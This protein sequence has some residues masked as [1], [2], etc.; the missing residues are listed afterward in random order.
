[1]FILR[2]IEAISATLETWVDD[3]LDDKVFDNEDKLGQAQKGFVQGEAGTA[4]GW[5][6]YVEDGYTLAGFAI[7]VAEGVYVGG[8][9]Q[10]SSFHGLQSELEWLLRGVAAHEDAVQEFPPIQD[11]ADPAGFLKLM[12]SLRQLGNGAQLTATIADANGPRLRRLLRRRKDSLTKDVLWLLRDRRAFAEVQNEAPLFFGTVNF[13]G[14]LPLLG[15]K[16]SDGTRLLTVWAALVLP[17]WPL[18]QYVVLHDGGRYQFLG[19]LTAG[20]GVWTARVII[21][22]LAVALCVLGKLQANAT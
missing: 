19:K 15:R 4:G 20:K 11:A 13:L 10:G 3:K 22:S 8:D 21:A 12:P 17:L 6:S 9:G 16:F 7:R 1:V 14:T 18:G 5:F 2:R